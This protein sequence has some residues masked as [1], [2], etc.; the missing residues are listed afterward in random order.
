MTFAT[1]NGHPASRVLVRVP[2][3]GAWFADIDLEGDPNVSGRVTIALG[4]LELEG[5]VRP[6]QSG[7]HG[8]QRRLQVVAGGDGWGDLLGAKAYHNDSRV[9]ARTVAEDAAREAGEELGDFAPS[10]ERIGIDYVRQSGPAARVL[11]DVIGAVPW[12]VDYAG[13]TQVGTRGSAEAS[14]DAY[15]VLEHEPRDRV[16]TLAVDDLSAIT[17]GSVLSARLDEPQTVRELELDVGPERVRVRAWCGEDSGRGHLWGL[18]RALARRAT[19]DRLYGCWRYRVVQMSGDRVELQAVRRDAGLPDIK[20]ISMWPGIAGVHAELAGSTEVLVEFIEGDRA[21]PIITHY[22]GRVSPG[23][24]LGASPWLPVSIVHDAQ[25]TI[26]LGGGVT[27]KLAF[28]EDVAAAFADVQ[29]T[30][31]TFTP[32]TGGAEFPT[33]FIAPSA[34][35]LA[36]TKVEAE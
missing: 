11:E 16:V 31:D 4:A 14:A 13:R 27:K 21:Q 6:S 29:T 1:V 30:I 25:E 34:G 22:L 36:T 9:R 18:V 8:L 5:T 17:I 20:P 3:R 12:W 35:D 19:D 24:I 10:A 32:G 26:R 7:T 23:E 33:P 2:G 28:A 15:E